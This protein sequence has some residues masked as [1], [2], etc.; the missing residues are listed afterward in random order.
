[1]LSFTMHKSVPLIH[2]FFILERRVNLIS[3]TAVLAHVG[4][5]TFASLTELILI[6]IDIRRQWHLLVQIR[7]GLTIREVD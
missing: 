6:A 5:T 1:M 3:I 7:A 2:N 4:V